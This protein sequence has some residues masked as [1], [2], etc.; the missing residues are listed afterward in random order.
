MIVNPL[1]VHPLWHLP[2]ESRSCGKNSVVLG[3]GGGKYS[4]AC[5]EGRFRPGGP[6][7]DCT[8]CPKTIQISKDS[9]C[10]FGQAVGGTFQVRTLSC[11]W[12]F[13]SMFLV[14]YRIC[15]TLSTAHK[16]ALKFEQCESLRC[17]LI[18]PCAAAILITFLTTD[19]ARG[20]HGLQISNTRRHHKGFG[21][22]ATDSHHG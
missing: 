16:S 2:I 11:N 9:P 18:S 10:T 12:T 20:V 6:N 7:P 13:L 8:E 15:L 3:V 21:W 5:S 1:H 22:I 14:D 19:W 4:G 17:G